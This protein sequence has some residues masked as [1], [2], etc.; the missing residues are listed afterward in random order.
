ML[1]VKNAII[2]LL[3]A[4]IAAGGAIAAFASNPAGNS[5]NVEVTVWQRVSD[6]AIFLSTRSEGGEWT[7]HNTAI[8]LGKMSESGLY[9]QSSAV[10]LAVA[11]GAPAKGNAQA[12]AVWLVDQALARYE[13]DGLQATLDYYNSGASVDG[14]WYVFVI[15]EDSSLIGHYDDNVRGKLLDGPLGTDVTG[16]EYGKAMLAA[17]ES[18]RWVTYVFNNPATGDPQRKHS[19]VVKRDG[20]LFGSG[21]YDFSSYAAPA[22]PK[23]SV[24]AYTVWLVDQALARYERDGLQATLDYYNSPEALDGPWYVFMIEDRDGA[25]YSVANSNRPDIV[26]T[27]RERI[28][29]EGF[30]YGEAFAQVVDGGAGEWVRYWFTHPETDEDAVKHTWIVRV[31]DYLFGAGWYEGISSE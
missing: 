5:T 21:W 25:L 2:G 7:T 9:R 27:T 20:R 26:G 17:D 1:N 4:V 28:D 6:G 24:E 31:G 19:W 15:G 8:D 22:P 13:R 14:S 18:G 10:R 11:D 29:R 23:T 16:Y 12:Y 30:N 3:I